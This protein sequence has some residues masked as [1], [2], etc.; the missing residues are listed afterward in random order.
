MVDS[1]RL[2]GVPPSS[3]A[4]FTQVGR[5]CVVRLVLDG[6]DAT[7]EFWQDPGDPLGSDSRRGFGLAAFLSDLAENWRGWEG[8]KS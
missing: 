4:E 8:V 6:L 5:G 7:T 3:Y 1:L 2:E